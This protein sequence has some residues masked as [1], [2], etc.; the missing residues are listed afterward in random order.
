[1]PGG[2]HAAF[3]LTGA[4]PLIRAYAIVAAEVFDVGDCLNLDGAG[5]LK[6]LSAANQDV[7]GASLG[8]VGG[9]TTGQSDADELRPYFSVVTTGKHEP[10]LIF[11]PT[12]VFETDD[13]GAKGTAVVGDIGEVSDLEVT[14]NVWGIANG[15]SGTGSTPQFRTIDIERTRATYLVVP[16]IIKVASVFQ[17]YDASV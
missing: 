7:L 14:S 15:T 16:D 6:E 5:A 11:C 1:M 13:E 12:T 9:S 4:P 17:W 2:F 3:T 10:C 8:K